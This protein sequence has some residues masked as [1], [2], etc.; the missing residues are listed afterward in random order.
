MVG[1]RLTSGTTKQLPGETTR[2][3]ELSFYVRVVSHKQILQHYVLMARKTEPA[4][5]YRGSKAEG[6]DV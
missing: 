3:E 5:T 4:R 2:A 6:A 1:A